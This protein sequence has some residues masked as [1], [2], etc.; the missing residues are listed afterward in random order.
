M[1]AAAFSDGEV[2]YWFVFAR[3]GQV[4]PTSESSSTTQFVPVNGIS[5]AFDSYG[6]S[7]AAP[8]VLMHGLGGSR[9]SWAGIAESL[10][11][12]Y[13]VYVLDMRGH[14]ESD[15][16]GSYSF[17][18]MAADIVE[19]L[20]AMD[21]DDVSLIGHSMG[22]AATLL[23][24]QQNPQRMGRLVLEDTPLLRPDRA[25]TRPRTRPDGPLPFDWLVVEAIVDQ[26]NHPDP[27]WWDGLPLINTP[28]LFIGGG[29]ESTVDQGLLAETAAA[30]SN[31]RLV[32][33]P[34]GHYVHANRPV[35][36][37]EAVLDFLPQ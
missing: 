30:V 24:V 23:A 5:L 7:S 9:T 10:A 13:S 2:P 8:V 17:E 34:A 15:W 36:F 35:E 14:G 19:F 33:I 25:G 3:M 26:L 28:G 31:S 11:S 18:L 22:G 16:P 1:P 12:Q 37:L 27:S 6:N 29:P 20:D 32:T 21:L 4:T